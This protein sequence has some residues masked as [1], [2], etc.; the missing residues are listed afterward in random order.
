MSDD[1]ERHR[2]SPSVIRVRLE[3]DFF[4]RAVERYIDENKPDPVV[5]KQMEQWQFRWDDDGDDRNEPT[6][7]SLSFEPSHSLEGTLTWKGDYVAI[8]LLCRC[9]WKGDK[10]GSLFFSCDASARFLS[11]DEMD[12]RTTVDETTGDN[13]KKEAAIRKRMQQ[14]LRQ[15]DYI[16]KLFDSD[17]GLD[18]CEASVR[19]EDGQ[20][21]E[22][23]HYSDV[24]MEGVRRA[25]FSKAD[26]SLD[27]L[28]VALH[29]P[30]LPGK[31]RHGGEVVSSPATTTALADRAKL[32]LL[33][34]AC[35]DE[36][37]KEGEEELVQDL[38]LSSSSK[39]CRHDH[40]G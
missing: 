10:E 22:R 12:E 20:L 6:S 31:A 39:R 24:C 30:L 17:P 13:R 29:M 9:H 15:D 1:E 8:L 7:T 40:S 5:R 34:D 35:Y 3:S 26:S 27:V 28:D 25:V 32:R 36:C 33:E 37:E 16:T 21:E 4:L 11:D 19:V 23:V 2:Q 14:R 18:F 38:Q